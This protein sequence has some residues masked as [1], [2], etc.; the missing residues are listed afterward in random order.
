MSLDLYTIVY[1][2]TNIFTAEIIR[3]FMNI[4]FEKRRTPIGVCIA[5]YAGYYCFTGI[6]YLFINIPFLTLITCFSTIF[7]VALNYQ[8]DIKKHLISSLYV[9][10]FLVGTE[11]LIGAF[12][13]YFQF[14]FFLPGSYS[15]I[16]GLVLTR[17]LN[18]FEAIVFQ[19]FKSI[20]ANHSINAKVWLSLVF[21]PVSTIFL[22]MYIVDAIEISKTRAIITIVL[23]L[24]LNVAAFYSYDALSASYQKIMQAEFT[25]VESEMYKTQCQLMQES[26]EKMKYFRHDMR[27]QFAAM[28]KL[29]EK[30]EYA[31]LKQQLAELSEKVSVNTSYSNTGNLAVDSIVNFKLQNAG[32]D[33]IEVETEIAIP[34]KMEIE[35]SD[36]V[37][38]I[39]N[40][41]DNALQALQLVEQNR[42]L[43]L[44]IVYS[45]DCLL[46]RVQNRYAH[47][48][49]YENGEIVTTKEKKE[50]HGIGLKSM[51][52]IVERYNGYMKLNHGDDL[53]TVD[54]LLYLL[55]D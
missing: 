20:R 17:L 19:E 7:L 55:N 41:L 2:V 52:N 6:V 3:K 34:S 39:G 10:L 11:I 43:Y 27:N 23:I 46:I 16:F 38:L 40:M 50:E 8:G 48:I 18:Y 44:K 15:N 51:R 1:L 31:A 29:L 5:S 37:S 32:K 4:F 12:T 28:D 30:K 24:L 26:T 36:I 21:I 25:A 47:E 22:R 14:S 54:I 35:I 45:M 13:N 33:H 53:F 49:K 42:Y 9:L